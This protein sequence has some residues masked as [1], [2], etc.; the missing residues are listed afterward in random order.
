MAEYH[1]NYTGPQIDTGIAKANTAAQPADLAN[2]QNTIDSSHKL[3]ADLVDD[4]STTN[5]F[6]TASD[7]TTWSGKQDALV[8]GTNIKTI[9]NESL[10]G[11]GNITIGGGSSTDIVKD[12]ALLENIRQLSSLATYPL[13][14]IQGNVAILGDSTIA[15]QASSKIASLISVASGYTITDLSVSGDT[16]GGQLSK[17]NNLAASVKSN[18]TYV[19][20]EVGINDVSITHVTSTIKNSYTN[21]VNKIKQDT[22]N[23]EVIIC[24]MTPCKG[25]W[26][27]LY[28]SNWQLYETVFE[29]VNESIKNNEYGA[30]KV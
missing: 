6:V 11:S 10:L 19:F 12:R 23:A 21:L 17:W 30:T 29:E 2:K 24:T 4:T 22:S 1:S 5:K 25:R 20:V 15:G 9:N 14:P 27:A 16:I 26:K 18:L 13:L 7:K 8:S 28:G 3:S